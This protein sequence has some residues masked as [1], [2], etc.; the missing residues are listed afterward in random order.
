MMQMVLQKEYKYNCWQLHRLKKFFH[1]YYR[2]RQRCRNNYSLKQAICHL[3]NCRLHCIRP[4]DCQFRPDHKQDATGIHTHIVQ[5]LFLLRRGGKRKRIR[6]GQTLNNNP[7]VVHKNGF[8]CLFFER[9]KQKNA[10]SPINIHIYI[11]P[12]HCQLSI[13]K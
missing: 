11:R 3:S 1:W 7:N 6:R 4:Q 13:I 5:A 12:K 2:Y 8:R 9:R 10:E